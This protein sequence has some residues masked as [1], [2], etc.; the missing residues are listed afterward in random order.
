MYHMQ[1]VAGAMCVGGYADG[2]P[3]IKVA[4]SAEFGMLGP[5]DRPIGWIITSSSYDL[6]LL[7]LAQRRT[8]GRFGARLSSKPVA[9]P[10]GKRVSWIVVPDDYSSCLLRSVDCETGT[11]VEHKIK[12]PARWRLTHH[13]TCLD[14]GRI[15]LLLEEDNLLQVVTIDPA[16]GTP[17]FAMPID[18]RA[19]R[20]PERPF[21]FSPSGK[22]VL[23]AALGEPITLWTLDPARVVRKLPVDSSIAGD[24]FVWQGDET[25][26]WTQ[27]E[28]MA[29]C[30]GVDGTR[31]PP[32]RLARKG[33]LRDAWDIAPSRI[34]ALGNRRARLTLP[35]RD[36]DNGDPTP[37]STVEVDGAPDN[38]VKKPRVIS[39]AADKYVNLGI[40]EI[41][42]ARLPALFK[43]VQQTVKDANTVLVTVI[44][45]KPASRVAALDTMTAII[46]DHAFWTARQADGFSDWRFAFDIGGKK[47]AKRVTE[48]AYCQWLIDNKMVSAV[49]ALRRAISTYL[50]WLRL[51]DHP[52]FDSDRGIAALAHPMRALLLLDPVKSRDVFLRYLDGLD[53]GHASA[54]WKLI[55]GAFVK[56]HALKTKD[57]VRLGLAVMLHEL[58]SA[59][60]SGGAMWKG[61][62][63]VA[64]A[65][66]IMTGDV[67]GDLVMAAMD[68]MDA[69][70]QDNALY[71]TP[72]AMGATPVAATTYFAARSHSLEFDINELIG[73][74]LE[75]VPSNSAFGKS[76]RFKLAERWN[77]TAIE[78]DIEEHT[79]TMNSG[80]QAISD[81]NYEAGLRALLGESIGKHALLQPDVSKLIK[82]SVAEL[83]KLLR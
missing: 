83:R 23:I 31:S 33:K 77:V 9:T 47:T 38:Q 1:D 10:D 56:E 72:D 64:S 68:A 5:V 67:F 28:G 73:P 35:S 17:T 36:D 15:R 24:G 40:H 55:F 58:N 11:L 45:D 66:Q 8:I 44:D 53:D 4:S 14:D 69:R 18:S 61:F 78:A 59:S 82:S 54:T 50:A 12:G 25:A 57:D 27:A 63:V 71:D 65:R 43:V 26:F 32:I 16:I 3:W 13:V 74:L 75:H 39:R 46:G 81:G 34:E 20:K 52:Y 60:N 37:L 51:T 22:Y 7:D 80:F 19:E 29:V 21:S 41:G 76:L 49:P 79:D 6:V 62:E 48:Q 70:K 30:V 42:P 2:K